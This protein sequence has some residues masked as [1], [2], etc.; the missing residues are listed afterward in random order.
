MSIDKATEFDPD[1]PEWTVADFV[2]AEPAEA[3]SE[4]ELAAFPRT[5]ARLRRGRPTGST[6]EQI[7]LRVDKDV[8]RRFR[9]EGAGW[10][11]RM[12]EALRKAVGL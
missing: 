5:A 6:K 9:A 4:A 8:L 2:R 1:N 11:T 7:A 10:Q 3:L 12:N